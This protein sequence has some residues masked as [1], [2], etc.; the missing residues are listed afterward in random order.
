MV[1]P[2]TTVPLSL[3]DHEI[4]LVTLKQSDESEPIKCSLEAHVLDENCPEYVALSYT[5]GSKER[6]ADILLNGVMVPVGRS[7]WSF[8][9]EMRAQHQYIDFWIDAICIDQLNV[10]EQNHQ[11]QMMRQIYSKAQ[12]VWIWLGEADTV[13]NSDLAM[14]FFKISKHTGNPKPDLCK[15]WTPLIARAVWALCLRDY[16]SRIWM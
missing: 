10:L 7:L 1:N 14:Q 16:W 12:S 5:W 13:T 4:R 8:L 15:L 9:Q 2:H 11:V 3:R 6:H